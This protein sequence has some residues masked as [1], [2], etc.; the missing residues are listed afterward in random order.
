MSPAA[1]TCKRCILAAGVP[2]QGGFGGADS[3]QARGGGVEKHQLQPALTRTQGQL[4]T[5]GLL[6]LRITQTPQLHLYAQREG[7]IKIVGGRVTHTLQF[8][9]PIFRS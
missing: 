2:N 8:K 3:Q 1:A 4:R 7:D 6:Q 9:G 5:A